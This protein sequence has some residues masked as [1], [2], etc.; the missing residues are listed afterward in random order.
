VSFDANGWTWNFSAVMG[1][2]TKWWYLAIEEEAA[3]GG[4][5]TERGIARGVLR[6][7]GRGV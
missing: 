4:G 7:I 1:T 3:A 6:G 5:L 2:A